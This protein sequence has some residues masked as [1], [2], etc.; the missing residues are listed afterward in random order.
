MPSTTETPSDTVSQKI[1]YISA[2]FTD[3][4][5]TSGTYGASSAANFNSLI[6]TINQCVA[7]L[8]AREITAAS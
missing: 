7:A 2:Y 5:V 3:L 1:P 4:S 8:N 6:Y